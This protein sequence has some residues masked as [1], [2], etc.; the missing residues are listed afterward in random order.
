MKVD[1]PA[2]ATH[3][4][5]DPKSVLMPIGDFLLKTSIIY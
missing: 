5:K 2:I 3:L 1:T 4:L